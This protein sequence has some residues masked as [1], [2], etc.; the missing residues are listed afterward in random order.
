MANVPVVVVTAKDL[1]AEERAW[2]HERTRH[3]FQKPI[4][5]PM[6]LSVVRN[7]LKGVDHAHPVA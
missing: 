2:L 1:D 6:L 3:C 7:V 5:G 4:P